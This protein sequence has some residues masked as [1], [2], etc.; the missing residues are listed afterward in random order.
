MANTNEDYLVKPSLP[1][2]P[3][4]VDCWAFMFPSVLM[5]LKVDLRGNRLKRVPETETPQKPGNYCQGFFHS[6]RSH[7]VCINPMEES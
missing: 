4:T 7:P 3:A 2:F 1:V 6:R 5:S